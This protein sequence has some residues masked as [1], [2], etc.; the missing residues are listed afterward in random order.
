MFVAVAIVSAAVVAVAI[1]VGIETETGTGTGIGI[2]IGIGIGTGTGS[3][4]GTGIATVMVAHHFDA[5]LHRLKFS[6]SHRYNCFLIIIQNI[7][8]Y[9]NC[10]IIKS[11]SKI[12]KIKLA[13][14]QTSE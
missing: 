8:Q 10:C 9:V 2:G 3:E 12:I 7:L 13:N 11:I 6:Y 5:H 4:I 14:V 1:G